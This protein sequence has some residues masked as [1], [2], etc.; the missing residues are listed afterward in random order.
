MY[1]RS[2]DVLTSSDPVFYGRI[3]GSDTDMIIDYL[4]GEMAGESVP[5]LLA[6]VRPHHDNLALYNGYYDKVN[7]Q[8]NLIRFCDL[9]LTCY[10]SLVHASLVGK[11]WQTLYFKASLNPKHCVEVG[12]KSRVYDYLLETL[13]TGDHEVYLYP[14]GFIEKTTRHKWSMFNAFREILVDRRVLVVSPFSGSI[15]KNFKNRAHFF[16]NYAY[17]EF[18]LITYTTPITYRGLPDDYYPDRDWFDTVEVIKTEVARMEFDIALLGCGSYAM[19]LGK[20]ICE[21][22]GRK[23]VYLG[24]VLQL[25]FGIMGRRYANPFFTDQINPEY[26]IT[27]EE[28]DRYMRHVT[29]A[30]KAPLEGFGAYF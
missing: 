24:G 27:A 22:M 20:H 3:G 16:R 17:P 28:G 18:S 8:D 25:Y 13:S 6:R 10:R 29:L 12:T 14:F 1:K 15:M 4:E 26:F 5:Q 2:V 11:K 23:A 30:S 21:V 19:P 7:I 9:M